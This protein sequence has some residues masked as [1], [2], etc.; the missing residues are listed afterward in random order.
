MDIPGSCIGLTC[1]AMAY[2]PLQRC[3]SYGA[4]RVFG[5]GAI[6]MSLLRSWARFSSLRSYKDF[7]PTELEVQCL[8]CVI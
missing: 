8:R 1:C 4:D 5:N 2:S 6:N 7:A 3:R